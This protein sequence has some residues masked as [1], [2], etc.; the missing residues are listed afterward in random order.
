MIDVEPMII[1]ELERMLPLPD[2]S[3]A[4]WGD[5]LGRAGLA[6]ARRL[7]RRRAFLLVGATALVG[8]AIAVPAFGLAHSVI[9]WFSAPTAPE[10]AQKSFQSLDI[11]A[12]AGMAPGVSGPARSVMDAQLDGKD[13][14]FWVAPTASGGFCFL[15]EGYGGGCDRN[16][17]L[18]LGWVV[19]GGTSPV[20]FGDTLPA[21]I[22][23]VEASFANGQN[24]SIP[25]VYV[26]SPIDAGFFVYQ[27]PGAGSPPEAW[28][29][30][31]EA[32]RGDGTV[33]GSV[34]ARG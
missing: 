7:P 25:V 13:A 24:V 6:G 26:S 28:P 5:V 27:L 29:A 12:P 33:A 23:H 8:L 11:G 9:D 1:S 18:P 21:G 31:L 3:A 34:T 17:Q 14:H 16:R 22:D 15:L 32:V 10:P 20:I 4:D 19:V 30:T 2:G